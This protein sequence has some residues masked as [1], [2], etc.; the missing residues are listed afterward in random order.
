MHD[1]I[2][3]FR[4]VA[5]IVVRYKINPWG[6]IDADK[7]GTIGEDSTSQGCDAARQRDVS[8]TRSTEGVRTDAGECLLIAVGGVEH[9][10]VGK[11]SLSDACG[12]IGQSDGS[13]CV[14]TLQN[15]G[16]NILDILWKRERPQRVTVV[17]RRVA[18][19]GYALRQQDLPDVM[20]AIERIVSDRLQTLTERYSGHGVI[21][22]EDII[23]NTLAGSGDSQRS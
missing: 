17:E 14:A 22:V 4:T 1:Y 18:Q 6:D 10:T 15:P 5:D 7:F 19:L 3:E 8:E 13:K 2:D 16:G 20:T 12:T 21:V 9:G 11:R 23:A